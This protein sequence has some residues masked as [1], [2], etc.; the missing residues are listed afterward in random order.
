[1]VNEQIIQFDQYQ[2]YKVTANA[3]NELRID[4][5]PFKILEV[6][7]NVHN[8]LGKFLPNDKIIYLD[9]EI[10][11]DLKN[12]N[13][14]IVGDATDLKL[15]DNSFDIVVALD[16]Y[17]HIPK[18]RRELFIYHTARVAKL[19][20]IVGTPFDSH[21]VNSKEKEV[22]DYWKSLFSISYRW[23]HEHY[24]NKLP[25]LDNTK[26]YISSI[27]YD[28]YTVSHG[29]L[30]LWGDFIKAHFCEVYSSQFQKILPFFY[31]Y[32][33]K[34]L[35]EKDFWSEPSYRHFLFFTRNT[36]LIDKL[37]FYFDQFKKTSSDQKYN[38]VISFL[39][40]I[41]LIVNQLAN[42]NNQLADRDRQIND[43]DHQLDNIQNSMSWKITSPLRFLNGKRRL[44]FMRVKN[45][46][47]LILRH[48][49]AKIFRLF[50]DPERYSEDYATWINKYDTLTKHDREAFKRKLEGLAKR[51]L[52]SI[53]MPTYNSNPMFLISAIESVKK[54][55]YPNWELCIADDASSKKET[56]SVL[57]KYAEGDP[58]I[59]IMFRKKN[60]H[61]S[62]A[63]N[64]ALSLAN[65]DYV[66]FLDHDDLIAETALFYFAEHISK[67][68]DVCF[69]YSDEDKINN[70]NERFSPYF[71]PDWNP[72]LFLSQ[73]YLC[74]LT[75]IK[76][77]LVDHVNGFRVGYE[78][79]QDYDLFL[80][81][82]KNISYEQIGHIPR[83]LYHW[84][85]HKGSTA[86]AMNEKSYAFKSGLKALNDYLTNIEAKAKANGFYY[87]ICY[88]IPKNPPL[89]SLIIPTRNGYKIL[90]NC[91]SS[92]VEKT[93]YKNYE[94][95]IIDNGSDEKNILNYLSDISAIKNI[96]I[97]RDNRPF[98]FSV[99]NNS[100]VKKAKGEY[101]ALINNDIEVI[102]PEWLDEMI[103]LAIQPGIG[104][105]GAKLLYPNGTIQHGGVILG[106]GGIAGHSH[107]HLPNKFSGYFNRMKLTHNVSA[108]TAACLVVKKSI[109]NEVDGL[110]EN[111]SVAFNDVDFCM[112][113]LEKGY[114]NVWTPYAELYHHESISRGLENTPA[115]IKRFNSEIKYMNEKWGQKLFTDPAYNPNL[116]NIHENFSLAFPPRVERI[117]R[118]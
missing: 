42:H 60:G 71:K 13:E 85:S 45:L 97:L 109:Y 32:Y 94:I 99:L 23:L 59:K 69:I 25:S 113:I 92:I 33:Q 118:D 9:L 103:S 63:S 46:I 104:A 68:P 107:K 39:K 35:F 8:L 3:I 105:V 14:Y 73:N 100:A 18:E 95:I 6:G 96:K 44:I 75:L 62:L 28:C 4:N 80:R 87:K 84:R 74:H 29:N 83:I 114:R 72:Y 38:S 55:I 40:E 49:H 22:N 2:R 70:K 77:S 15:D 17:E 102:T 91:L 54:Q 52:I 51:P 21:A 115:K 12:N 53:L 11:P 78:G 64:S 108:V 76:K 7:S 111:L 24:T 117:N 88:E 101:I 27:G 43:R 30:E 82:I 67:N 47:K 110:D 66:G 57:N 86:L 36:D 81:V 89:I 65:G 93:T 106:I 58:R 34:Y 56:L 19:I 31:E 1:M 5:K 16:V 20:T 26:K 98:N 90:K 61:I 116:T 48:K 112:S 37:K 50:F 79:A 10:T 41:P